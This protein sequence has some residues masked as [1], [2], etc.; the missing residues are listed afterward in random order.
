M[1]ESRERPCRCT[2]ATIAGHTSDLV[3]IMDRQGESC[4]GLVGEAHP[5]WPATSDR[6]LT[7]LCA[8]PDDERR[9]S[10]GCASHRR[11]VRRVVRGRGPQAAQLDGGERVCQLIGYSRFDDPLIAGILVHVRMSPIWWREPMRQSCR[12][13]SD[14]VAIADAT[15]QDH[16]GVAV[17]GASARLPA[18]RDHQS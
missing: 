12:V 11:G 10:L 7:S 13:T 3:C 16:L 17:G 5:G 9:A 18:R 8:R 6:R 2:V 15:K 14:I 1:K 4:T